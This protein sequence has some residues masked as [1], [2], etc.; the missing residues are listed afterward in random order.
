MEVPFF[1]G[2]GQCWTGTGSP[3]P[4]PSF[5]LFFR[6]W[7]AHRHEMDIH[8]QWES[9]MAQWF[10]VFLA[11]DVC[12]GG[13][14]RE[15]NILLASAGILWSTCAPPPPMSEWRALPWLF[16]NHFYIAGALGVYIFSVDNATVT[17]SKN[18][19]LSVVAAGSARVQVTKLA[20]MNWAWAPPPH[21]Y[22]WCW[23]CAHC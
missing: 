12:R 7:Q 9:W 23:L 16:H 17:N 15:I 21:D 14:G 22:W 4:T 20:A 19:W 3:T 18:A 1:L 13:S 11:G 6:Q 8:S 10:C 2:G 5:S